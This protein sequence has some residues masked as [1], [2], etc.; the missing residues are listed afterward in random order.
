MLII[1]Y[2]V[3]YPI[4]KPLVYNL[5]LPIVSIHLHHLL[6]NTALGLAIRFESTGS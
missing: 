4:A 6:D 5:H 3:Y 1:V 2:T